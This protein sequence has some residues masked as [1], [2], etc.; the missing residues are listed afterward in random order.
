MYF[1]IQTFGLPSKCGEKYT[2]IPEYLQIWI[3]SG[4]IE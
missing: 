4:Q 1:D 3:I 2:G